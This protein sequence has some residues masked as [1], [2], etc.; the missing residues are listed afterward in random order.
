MRRDTAEA[1]GQSSQDSLIR[2][3]AA[4]PTVGRMPEFLTWTCAPRDAHGAAAPRASGLAR[5][6]EQASQ[7]GVPVWFLRV[8]GAS[9]PSHPAT[10]QAR[11]G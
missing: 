7:S 9:G 4:R 2:G 8:A 5:A 6:E 3:R 11:P 10:G 1:A